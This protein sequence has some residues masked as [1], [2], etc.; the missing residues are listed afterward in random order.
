MLSL[1]ATTIILT[2]SVGIIGANSLALGPIAPSIAADLGGST[3]TTLYAAGGYGLG[4]ALGALTL[5]PLIDRIGVQRAL[6]GA[7]IALASCFTASAVTP[8][9][10]GLI[11][12][13]SLA[14][15]AAGIGLPAIYA[16]AAEIAP[17]GQ[18]SKILGRVL[19]GWTLSL[20]AGVSLSSLLADLIHWRLV[21]GL[22][23]ILA[24]LCGLIVFLSR[25]P[26]SERSDIGLQF[27]LRAFGL[28]GVPALLTICFFFMVTFYGTYAFIGDHIHHTLNLPLRAGGLIAITYGTGFAL[29][30]LGDSL[31]DR[32]G[33]RS[34]M[35]WVMGMVT[36]TYALMAGFSGSFAALLILTA[37]WGAA[38]H[39]GL[40]LVV[41]SLSALH[42][43]KRGIVLGLN[44]AVTYLAASAGAFAFGPLYETQ[45]FAMLCG[46]ATVLMV[47]PVLIGFA[48]RLR[49]SIP[50][51]L[52][53]AD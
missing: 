3:S 36:L 15:L 22:L 40:N 33:T 31:I 27:P 20:V 11:I 16:Y 9:I 37:L 5:S 2:A 8:G 6:F 46:L 43:S 48:L 18:E 21:F 52:N 17:K 1:R 53:S 4:T 39:F 13:Q 23:S 47:L 45:G 41:G 38:N 29:A 7:L 25:P 24:L 49:P 19:V 32:H 34:L 44:S 10:S 14:G 26:K 42:P 35:P 51:A 50:S 12:A 28:P 30:S